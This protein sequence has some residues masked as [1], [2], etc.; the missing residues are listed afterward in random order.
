[1]LCGKLASEGHSKEENSHSGKMTRIKQMSQHKGLKRSVPTIGLNSDMEKAS[2][3]FREG[4]LDSGSQKLLSKYEK[5]C[6]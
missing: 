3:F 5:N 6:N 1:M 4:R 2:S